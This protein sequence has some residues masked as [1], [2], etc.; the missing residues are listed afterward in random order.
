MNRVILREYPELTFL[1]RDSSYTVAGAGLDTLSPFGYRQVTYLRPLAILSRADE[2]TACYSVYC[3][4][5]QGEKVSIVSII[6]IVS[7]VST[8]FAHELHTKW[9]RRLRKLIFRVSDS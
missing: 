3:V 4:H 8:A 2:S 7:I 1:V 6:S 9:E 5:K